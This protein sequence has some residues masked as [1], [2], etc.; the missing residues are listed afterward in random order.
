[1]VLYFCSVRQDFLRSVR[2][3]RGG[4]SAVLGVCQPGVYRDSRC[5]N[6]RCWLAC[7]P[8]ARCYVG[9]SDVDL[10]VARDGNLYFA[11]MLFD[12]DAGEGRL[13]TI[14]VSRDIGAS[15]GWTTLSRTRFDDR[16]WVEVAPDGTA[17]VIWNDGSGVSHAVSRDRGATW[18]EMD[19]IHDQGG[20]SHL[21]IGPS[22]EL[23]VRI[24]PLSASGNKF[25]AGVDLI[26]VSS[27][28][29]RLLAEASRPGRARLVPRPRGAREHTP[30]GRAAGLGPSR[31]ALLAMDRQD[32]RAVGAVEGS[33][34][35]LEDVGGRTGSPT[36]LFPL[37][38]R[39]WFPT[40][41][42]R[43]G[44]RRPTRTCAT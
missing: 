42:L 2:S 36:G 6:G 14:G 21:A 16:P 40:S 37:S 13:I 17:H 35:E 44:S 9:N 24:A 12:R 19:R 8:L 3:V 11:T 32:G 15:W 31:P 25:H 28:A 5:L 43:P 10:A 33:W 20:S 41:W 30:M 27:D 29:R 18:M 39:H 22:G 7:G 1:M 34:H 38:G 23:A 4:H 26:A